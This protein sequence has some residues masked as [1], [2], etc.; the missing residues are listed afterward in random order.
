MNQLTLEDDG[1]FQL[2]NVRTKLDF[3]LHECS[4]LTRRCRRHVNGQWPL[5]RFEQTPERWW[6]LQQEPTFQESSG[7]QPKATGSGNEKGSPNTILIFEILTLN[8]RMEHLLL[9]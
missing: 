4:F 6:N 5:Q 7:F 1:I 8:Q 3:S 9:K 2:Q